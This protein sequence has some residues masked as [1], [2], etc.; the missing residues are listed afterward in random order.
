[1]K[2]DP[3]KQYERN[4]AEIEPEMAAIKEGIKDLDQNGHKVVRALIHTTANIV[5]VHAVKDNLD[6]ER[7]ADVA[8][9][10]LKGSILFQY[11]QQLKKKLQ[12]N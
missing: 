5:A 8:A 12:S 10:L 3:K 2:L 6:I 4:M 9:N 11:Q 1:M 7:G